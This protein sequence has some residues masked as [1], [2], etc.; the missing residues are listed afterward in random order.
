MLPLPMKLGKHTLKTSDGVKI[1]AVLRE[2]ADPKGWLILVHMMPATK[3]SWK[4]FAEAMQKEGYE[5]LAIDLRGHGE[6]K[7]GPDGFK[8][9]NDAA[10]QASI[11][12][13]EAAWEFLK[14]RGAVPDK[15]TVVGASIGANLSLQFLTKNSEVQRCILLSPG[16]Y[17]GI[18]SGE[19][20]KSLHSGQRV[21]FVASRKD[22][23][24]NGNNAEQNEA[25]YNTMPDGV[26]KKLIIYESAGH[27]T[28]F[29]ESKE[30]SDL[31]EAI[32]IFLT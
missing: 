15:L 10:H 25:Y 8:N 32:K 29:L 31:T 13:L 12:D 28:D 22:D 17:R 2:V 27:G 19:L 16:D 18:D 21:L 9:F 3:E 26:E 30:A 1:S 14:S 20:V 24:S 23:R 11:H 7:G 5:N 4:D 6:S